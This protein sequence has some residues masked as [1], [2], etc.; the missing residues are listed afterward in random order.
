[1][2]EAQSQAGKVEQMAPAF[3]GNSQ[4]HILKPFR[5]GFVVAI[6]KQISIH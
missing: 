6:K 5:G 4:R 1:M 3:A 2:I